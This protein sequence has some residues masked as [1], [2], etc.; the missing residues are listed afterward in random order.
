MY[1]MGAVAARKS[2]TQGKCIIDWYFGDKRADRNG[3]I[4]AGMEKYPDTRPSVIFVL[5]TEQACGKY[6]K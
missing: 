4:L 3:L 5:V 1:A 6:Y 2:T